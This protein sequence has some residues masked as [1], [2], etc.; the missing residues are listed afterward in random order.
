MNIY[1]LCISFILKHDYRKLLGRSKSFFNTL[2]M[3][4]HMK[5]INNLIQHPSLPS[6]F[7]P[8]FL[9]SIHQFVID[10]WSS[11]PKTI[12]LCKLIC[13]FVHIRFQW[14]YRDPVILVSRYILYFLSSLYAPHQP[15][16]HTLSIHTHAHTFSPVP[17]LISHF[18]RIILVLIHVHIVS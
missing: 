10:S 12:F 5:D 2:I 16:S 15:Y 7:I 9:L 8:I 1:N 11:Y 6:S 18:F 13:M 17:I 4:Y 14:Q 3:F